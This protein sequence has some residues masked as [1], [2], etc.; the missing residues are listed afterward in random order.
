MA[1]L[2][3]AKLSVALG[4]LST[5]IVG[6]SAIVEHCVH[7]D[8][9][10]HGKSIV[11]CDISLRIDLSRITVYAATGCVQDCDLGFR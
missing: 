9:M 3:R 6:L 11:S 10:S 8:L 7:L 5:T 4:A 1:H 2:S